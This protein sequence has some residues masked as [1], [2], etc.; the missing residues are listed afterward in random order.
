MCVSFR[1]RRCFRR[2]GRRAPSR[3]RMPSSRT[4]VAR[5]ARR[6]T[7]PPLLPQ[8]PPPPPPPLPLPLLSSPDARSH[9]GR[10]TPNSSSV[11]GHSST[12]S[13]SPPPSSSSPPPSS[14]P[15]SSARGRLEPMSACCITRWLS[16]GN[17]CARA[18]VLLDTRR[19]QQLY[20]YKSTFL[21]NAAL[22]V[23]KVVTHQPNTQSRHGGLTVAASAVSAISPQ[24]CNV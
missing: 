13:S 3:R 6:T 1:R 19:T 21:K 12:P 4:T 9:W 5:E 22:G 7:L 14:S 18:C 15:F 20:F 16:E 2:R 11:D 8:T 23:L 24:R 17:M 10:I